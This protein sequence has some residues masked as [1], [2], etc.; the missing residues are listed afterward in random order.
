MKST[1]YRN[2]TPKKLDQVSIDDIDNLRSNMFAQGRKNKRSYVDLQQVAIASNQQGGSGSVPGTS[3]IVAANNIYDNKST[4]YAPTIGTWI[5]EAI[6]FR[7]TGGNGQFTHDI[8]L[9]HDNGAEMIVFRDE[10]DAADIVAI[11]A[12]IE[13]DDNITVQAFTSGGGTTP[14]D[15]SAFAYLMRRR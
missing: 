12:E 5:L 10:K 4:L 1:V 2:L 7:V 11:R 3:I 9:A 13:I 15:V 6:E 8:F 14:T